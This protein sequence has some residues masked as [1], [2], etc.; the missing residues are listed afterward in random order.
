MSSPPHE[1]RESC[2]GSPD[3]RLPDELR[4]PLRAHLNDLR[5]KYLRRGWAGRVGFG[6]RPALVV[7]DLARFWLDARQQIGSDLDAVVQAACAVLDAAR[8]A[9]V[10]VFFTTYAHD[11]ATP[12]SPQQRKLRL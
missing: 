12:P 1:P 11:P 5:E 10:P 3:L 7:I 9:Q 2:F 6:S 8:A 4:G